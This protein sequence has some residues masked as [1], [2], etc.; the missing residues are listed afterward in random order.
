MPTAF[1]VSLFSRPANVSTHC[2][3]RSAL[4]FTAFLVTLF[5]A[6]SSKAAEP[7][8]GT[9]AV[10]LDAPDHNYES[11]TARGFTFHF[12]A[13]VKDGVLHGLEGKEGEP[14]SLT[15]DGKIKPDGTADL[16]VFGVVG[17]S[18]YAIGHLASGST[19]GY[20]VKAAFEGRHG[21]GT[22]VGG[23]PTSFTFDKK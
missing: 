8:D 10:V 17:H 4:L 23:R 7:F 20:L 14:G 18:E 1:R 6:Q 2:L 16:K 21:T 13:T 15:I 12:D 11:G 9:W 3:T 22:R 19:Y 5:L